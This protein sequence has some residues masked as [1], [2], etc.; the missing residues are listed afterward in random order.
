MEEECVRLEVRQSMFCGDG[1]W[2]KCNWHTL[3]T[4][5]KKMPPT[6]GKN[7]IAHHHKVIHLRGWDS[8]LIPRPDRMRIISSSLRRRNFAASKLNYASHFFLS[9]KFC[10]LTLIFFSQIGFRE[11]K[12]QTFQCVFPHFPIL[13]YNRYLFTLAI[14]DKHEVVGTAVAD[15]NASP[16]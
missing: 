5:W 9:C 4:P 6:T 3:R 15:G 8:I 13:P 7:G 1:P 10:A 16:K 14:L 11:L 12:N 2:K